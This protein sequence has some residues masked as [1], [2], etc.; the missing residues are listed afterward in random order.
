MIQNHNIDIKNIGFSYD[1][2]RVLDNVT[3]IIKENEMTAIVGISGSGKTTLCNLIARFW[4][5]NEGEIKIGG[6]NIKD[7]TVENLMDNISMVFQGVY[8]FED[9][10]E[11]NIKF[12]NQ[13]ATREEVVNAAKKSSMP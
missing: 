7:Y 11:N 4:D 10:I 8:L 13:N 12:G 2:R 5:V 1:N 9:T 6:N 3:C